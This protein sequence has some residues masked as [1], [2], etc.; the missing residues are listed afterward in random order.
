MRVRIVM[1]KHT[2]GHV[3]GLCG[4]KAAVLA[5][6]HHAARSG[7]RARLPNGSRVRSPHQQR[8]FDAAIFQYSN[9]IIKE[10]GTVNHTF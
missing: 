2:C 10:L 4:L 3:G 6:G 9:L 1:G 8:V 5:H 7:V